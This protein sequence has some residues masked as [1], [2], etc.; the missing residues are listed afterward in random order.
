MKDWQDLMQAGNY[1][2]NTQLLPTEANASGSPAKVPDVDGEDAG[3]GHA[4]GDLNKTDLT[5]FDMT[6]LT[7]EY[8]VMDGWSNKSEI[9]TRRI[10]IYES[11]QFDGYAFYATPLTD[12]SGADFEQFYDNGSGDPFLTSVR[13]DLDGDGVSDFW[14]FALGTDYK[15][16]GVPGAADNYTPDIGDHA[17]FKDLHFEKISNADLRDRLRGLHDA[18]DLYRDFNSTITSGL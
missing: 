16:A 3:G 11:R 14:E 10:Y 2:Y 4:Y 5:N 7:I 15:K 12:A 13:K 17:T 9:I 8:R 6:T 1:G 18:S